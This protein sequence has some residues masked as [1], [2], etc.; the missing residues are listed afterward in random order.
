MNQHLNCYSMLQ[1]NKEQ[2]ADHV[3]FVLL[4]LFPI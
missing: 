2:V 3:H 1:Q 4:H